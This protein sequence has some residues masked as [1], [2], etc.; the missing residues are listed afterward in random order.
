M[1]GYLVCS[2]KHIDDLQ[3]R[4]DVQSA[5]LNYIQHKSQSAK[6]LIIEEHG[7]HGDN[8]HW[9]IFLEHKTPAHL[10]DIFKTYYTDEYY[11]KGVTVRSQRVKTDIDAAFI[12]NGYLT[13]E[14]DS[15]VI[16]DTL[17]DSFKKELSTLYQ[18]HTHKVTSKEKTIKR[19]C[20]LTD[21]EFFNILY[22][23]FYPMYEKCIEEGSEFVITEH[24]YRDV[25]MS[26]G[27]D[28]MIV[29]HMN[30][31]KSFYVQ[32][33]MSYSDCTHDLLNSIIW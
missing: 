28:Y 24:E 11:M 15:I 8:P 23:A 14:K 12:I 31:L 19:F 29:Q 22:D 32:L 2:F 17:T 18:L 13:K 26:I 33:K 5:I 1:Y 30:K 16:Y 7:E 21:T 3:K 10:L 25:V 9:N 6:K 20:R 27:K 4:S